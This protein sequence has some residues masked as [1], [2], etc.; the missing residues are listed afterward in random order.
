MESSIIYPQ[1]QNK[2]RKLRVK[3]IKQKLFLTQQKLREEAA[4]DH[5]PTISLKKFR[6]FVDKIEDNDLR[7]KVQL[8]Y[9]TA[10]RM[11]EASTKVLSLI[12]I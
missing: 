8:Y 2:K 4:K 11:S 6:N 7:A 12:H 1:S 9:L 10:A 3:D 5:A